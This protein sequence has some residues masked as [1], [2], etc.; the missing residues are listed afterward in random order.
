MVCAF[1]WI[2]VMFSLTRGAV[3]SVARVAV[4]SVR[5]AP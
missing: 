2:S 1:Y 5:E 3:R 4:I